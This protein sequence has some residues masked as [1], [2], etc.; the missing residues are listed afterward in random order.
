MAKVENFE[1]LMIYQIAIKIGDII[2]ETAQRFESFGKDTLGK[3]MVR[4]ADSI[5][6]NIAEGFGRYSFKESRQFYY[7]ARGSLY[8]TITWV[9][10]SKK[11]MLITQNQYNIIIELINKLSPML[12]KFISTI[13]EKT[14]DENSH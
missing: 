12:N 4:A 1:D 9:N 5:A 8:E 14:S 2:W 13:K 10:K 7:Y 11:R 6:A 3:Q